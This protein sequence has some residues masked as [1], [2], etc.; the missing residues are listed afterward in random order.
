M[1]N[2]KQSK[3]TFGFKDVDKDEKIGLVK[4]V[5]ESVAIK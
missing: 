1:T 2:N 4:N 3:T 5:F